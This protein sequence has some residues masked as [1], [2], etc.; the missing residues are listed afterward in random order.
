MIRRFALPTLA[1]ASAV[2][3]FV[4]LCWLSVYN[5]P[6]AADD[7]CWAFMTRDHGVLWS[8]KFYYDNW[9]GRYMASLVFHLTPLGWGGYWYYKLVPVLALV[10]FGIVVFRLVKQIFGDDFV[11]SVTL[12][13]C[14]FLLFFLQIA[15]LSE[16]IY[17]I[18][19][20]YTYF[21]PQTLVLFF[22]TILLKKYP[23]IPI[24]TTLLLE[25]LLFVVIGLHEMFLLF[26]VGGLLA[27]FAYEGLFQKRVSTT[28]VVLLL[29]ALASSALVMFSPGQQLR[30]AGNP[31]GGQVGF[32]LIS[33]VK[34]LAFELPKWLPM[35]GL[36]GILY[37]FWLLRRTTW[38]RLFQGNILIVSGF[39][40]AV[41]V[42]MVFTS[43]YGIGI[44]PTPR[45]WNTTYF[46]FLTGGFHVL[47]TAAWLIRGV[48]L[49][50]LRFYGTV[51]CVMGILFLVRNNA[52]LK[53]V[54]GDIRYGTAA[55]YDRELTERQANI[56]QSK[57]DTVYV[58]PLKYQPKSL[59]MEDMRDNPAFLWNKCQAETFGK[60]AII[61]KD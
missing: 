36:F 25:L 6:S 21:I 7:Y 9:T 13:A 51:F 41:W 61:L 2:L 45:I 5:Q 50:K 1:I 32:S 31:L 39:W 17:W 58:A 35:A 48:N 30:Q 43:Y 52:N 16:A 12:T 14:F 11:Q 34:A 29:V 44:S 26:S 10:F 27:L 38:P 37:V 47:G 20:T 33:S 23:K 22:W 3:L 59:F 60:K 55:N 18:T 15:S 57:A 42:M 56:L 19:A 8:A 4:G 46:F 53:M 24:K 54:Y 40:V 28:T 49:G